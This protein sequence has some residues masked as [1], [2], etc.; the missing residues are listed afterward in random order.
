MNIVAEYNETHLLNNKFRLTM[1]YV[2]TVLSA[3]L[4]PDEPMALTSLSLSDMI[5]NYGMLT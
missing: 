2:C 4:A 5:E 1:L 3:N